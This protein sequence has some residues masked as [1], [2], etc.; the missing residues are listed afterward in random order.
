M[1]AENLTLDVTVAGTVGSMGGTGANI[2]SYR[3]R[4]NE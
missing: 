2:P 3:Q 1:K 4:P